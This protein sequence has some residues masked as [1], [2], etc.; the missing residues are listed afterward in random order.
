[1]VKLFK[2]KDQ[3]KIADGTASTEKPTLLMEKA[4]AFQETVLVLFAFLKAFAL[5]IQELQTDHYHQ[6]IDELS[7]S[8]QNTTK[9][10]RTTFHF[11]KQKDSI[12]NF[13][14]AQHK[15]IA[16]REKELRDIIDL[17]TKAMASLTAENQQFYK[18]VQD[19]G[20]KLLELSLL[21][22]IKKIKKSL[23]EEVEHMRSLVASKKDLEQR[24]IQLLAGQVTELQ[25][26]LEHVRAK[27][28]I[29]GLTSTFNR[30]A[31][32]EHLAEKIESLK[33]E[34]SDFCLLLLDMDDFKS[35]NDTYGHLIGDRMLMAFSQKCRSLIRSDDFF[36]RYG[37]EEF[38]IVLNSISLRDGLKKA[39][40]I[41]GT[42]AAARYAIEENQADD[43][44]SMT[45]S[46]GVTPANKND[47]IETLIARADKALYDA[48]RKGKNMAVGRKN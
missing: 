6:K 15:Y 4:A 2:I 9:P 35:L 36:A 19:Q 27:S 47:T 21:D 34:S 7:E 5:D 31:L 16:D 38:A 29:D 37:G 20:E 33:T 48:K 45:V 39:S 32:D 28:M 12:Q 43:Y 41:C 3:N 13:I 11:E 18:R 1:M 10:K 30:Q 22:D 46:I 40:D 25:Q 26:E 8:Y 14:D 42:V 23:Q 44:L 24:Q 17:L